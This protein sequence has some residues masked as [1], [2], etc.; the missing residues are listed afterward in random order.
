VELREVVLRDKPVEM[1]AVSAKGTVPVLVLPSGEVIDESLD[2]MRWALAISDPGNWLE[3]DSEEIIQRND[4]VLKPL[5]D[6]YKYSD[7]YPEKSQLDYRA[8]A[9]LILAEFDSLL[10]IRR[11]LCSDSISLAD[12]AIFPFL[13][14]FAY[15]DK[16]WFDGSSY[17]GLQRWLGKFLQSARF[18]NVMAKHTPW[19]PGVDAVVFGA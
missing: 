2:I 10:T 9:E 12:I 17:T 1:L 6:R 5:L 3:A 16:Q 19:K 4:T 15:V 14:Q 7:R 8:E 11:Y 18:T 13:R